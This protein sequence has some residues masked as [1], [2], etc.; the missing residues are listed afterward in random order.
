MRRITGRIGIGEKVADR[1]SCT[2]ALRL[3]ILGRTLL[4][5]A[6]GSTRALGS[7][8]DLLGKAAQI[9]VSANRPPARIELGRRCVE[10]GGL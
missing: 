6:C 5:A 3:T 10:F 8:G 2:P 7:A 9:G 4:I 1:P